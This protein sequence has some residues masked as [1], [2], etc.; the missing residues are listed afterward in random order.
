[1][2]AVVLG[3]AHNGLSPWRP[4]ALELSRGRHVRVYTNSILP[5][6]PRR[7]QPGHGRAAPRVPVGSNSSLCENPVLSTVKSLIFNA[8]TAARVAFSHRLIPG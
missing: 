4:N 3:I 1:M 7:R 5:S 8:A 2:V 6:R